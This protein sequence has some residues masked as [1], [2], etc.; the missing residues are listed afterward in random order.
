MDPL[1]DLAK[2][3]VRISDHILTVTMPMLKDKK[4]ILSA[5][6]HLEN[7]INH[8]MNYFIRKSKKPIPQD[9]DLLR[10]MFIQHYTGPQEIIDIVKKIDKIKNM[11]QREQISFI[12]GNDVVIL[13]N[14]YKTNV[15]KEEEIKEI[16]SEL[17]M[18]LAKLG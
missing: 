5:T 13:T 4:L 18:F 1:L 11:K 6:S 16:L 14:N 17:K 10:R 12:K 8:I 2:K 7:S 3:E 9:K 15:I